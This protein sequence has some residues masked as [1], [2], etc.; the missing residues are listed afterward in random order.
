[1]ADSERRAVVSGGSGGIGR[2]VVFA[3]AEAGYEVVALGRAADRLAALTDDARTRGHR[4]TTRVCDLTDDSAV[5]DLAG[6]LGPVSILVNNAGAARSARLRDTD[7]DLWHHHLDANATSAFLLTR[8]VLP[9]MRERDHGRVV[10]VA[11]TAAHVGTRYTVA[12]AAAKHAVLGLARSVAD[13]VAGTGVTSNAVCPAFV[14]TPM[15]E[16]SVARVAERTGRD[17]RQAERA[18]AESTPLGRLIE[19]EEV[20]AAVAYLASPLAGAVNGQS[21]TLDGGDTQR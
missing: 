9:G 18:L 15:T 7:V 19:P 13:E 16:R 2:A 4:V 6:A 14:R 17:P 10:F 1:M 11:S 3:L 5:A 20:A 8:A 21:L 12:Y